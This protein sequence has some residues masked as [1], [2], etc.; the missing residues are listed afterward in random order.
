MLHRTWRV[1]T[2]RTSGARGMPAVRLHKEMF[3]LSRENT[4]S[5]SEEKEAKRRLFLGGCG[6]CGCRG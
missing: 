5:F 3:F 4:S 1:E 6:C 2:A